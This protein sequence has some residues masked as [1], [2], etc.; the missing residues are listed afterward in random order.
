MKS[1]PKNQSGWAAIA[2]AAVGA[3]PKAGK[4]VVA[5]FLRRLVEVPE[6]VERVAR[7]MAEEEDLDWTTASGSAKREWKY[8]ARAALR[9]LNGY[10]FDTFGVDETKKI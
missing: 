5:G 8:R 4:W 7:A 1:A 3:L 10:V 9:G 2:G 6:C